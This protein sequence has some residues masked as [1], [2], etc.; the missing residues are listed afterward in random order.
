MDAELPVN[1]V[2]V[3]LNGMLGHSKLGAY[4]LVRI[5]AS[6]HRKYLQLSRGEFFHRFA[7]NTDLSPREDTYPVGLSHKNVT[8]VPKAR[9]STVLYV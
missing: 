4:H 2:K 1:V 3:D 9:S 6:Y 7:H 5:S 8:G